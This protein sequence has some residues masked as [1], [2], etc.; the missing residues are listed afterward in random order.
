MKL[1]SAYSLLLFFLLTSQAICFAEN[2]LNI[3]DYD[4]NVTSMSRRKILSTP[5]FNI[6]SGKLKAQDYQHGNRPYQIDYDLI[7]SKMKRK[8]PLVVQIPSLGVRED[9]QFI[10]W[11]VGRYF[12]KKGFSSLIVYPN[13]HP[14]AKQRPVVD[15]FGHIVRNTVATR[16]AIDFLET[17]MPQIDTENMVAFGISMGGVRM[18]HLLASEPRIKKGT[19][20]IGGDHLLDILANSL[21]PDVVKYRKCQMLLLDTKTITE[22]KNYLK[23]LPVHDA[24]HLAPYIGRDRVQMVIALFDAM[25]PTYNQ[26]TLWRT[27]GRPEIMALPTGHTSIAPFIKRILNFSYQGYKKVLDL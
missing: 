12:A 15:L 4:T 14:V 13:S 18:P 8:T 2:I 27:L 23:Q 19:I 24:K 17:N 3:Y 26:F 10:N 25:V 21:V 7:V 11:Y 9:S 16:Q 1:V 22:F 5:R 20:I 6:F